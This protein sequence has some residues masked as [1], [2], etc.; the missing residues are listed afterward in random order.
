MVKKH[1]ACALG[2]AVILGVCSTASAGARVRINHGDSPDLPLSASSTA[3]PVVSYAYDGYAGAAH[4][5]PQSF[6]FCNHVG[7]A[8]SPIDLVAQHGAWNYG[9][10]LPAPRPGVGTVVAV[11]GI[12]D[13]SYD[14][15]TLS[16]TTDSSTQSSTQ[17]FQ[18][19][20]GGQGITDAHHIFASGFD[21]GSAVTIAVDSIPPVNSSNP[22]TYT[23]TV[24]LRIPSASQAIYYL[25]EGYDTNVFSHCDISVP[26]L[27]I[28]SNI[29]LTR[30]CNVL[31]DVD[32]LQLDGTVPVVAA[33][34]FTGPNAGETDF[35]DN[36]AF[37]YPAVTP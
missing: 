13:I 34:L 18:A 9:S 26:R 23:I 24:S 11:S 35:G 4:V 17:C 14:G 21:P 31:P 19:D 30:S 20:K 27:A 15:Q 36:V 32:V 10:D 6:L 16:L 1:F 12:T 2:A 33:A 22:F 37:G 5:S 28:L 25:T 7:T 29:T 3:G 8:P